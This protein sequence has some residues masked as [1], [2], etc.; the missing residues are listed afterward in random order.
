MEAGRR[1]TCCA[2]GR[3]LLHPPW[4]VS[5]NDLLVH[6]V[7]EADMFERWCVLPVVS[8]DTATMIPALGAYGASLGLLG[9]PWLASR[10]TEAWI[11]APHSEPSPL[12]RLPMPGHWGGARG[13]QG[14][15]QSVHCR[16]SDGK[17]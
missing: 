10:C 5:L 6:C 17:R 2:E 3:S 13:A 16:P 11:S 14:C 9:E 8:G 7:E 1:L 15:R 12:P 4:L